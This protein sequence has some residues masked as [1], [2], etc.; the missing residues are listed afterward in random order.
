[1]TEPSAGNSAEQND[2]NPSAEEPA[3]AED[4]AGA[5]MPAAAEEPGEVEDPAEAV[6]PAAAAEEPDAAEIPAEAEDPAEAEEPAAAA[7]E[8]AEAEDP[9]WAEMPA[10]AEIAAEVEEPAEAEKPAEQ[11]IGARAP[12]KSLLKDRG[13]KVRAG[14]GA[15]AAVVLLGIAAALLALLGRPAVSVSSGEALVQVHLSGA[16]TAVT[17]VSATSA[18]RPVALS[19]QTTG[20]VPVAALPQGETVQVRVTAA[21]PSW[22][23][24][25][26]G[27]GVSTSATLR[28]PSAAPTA[29]VAVAAHPGRVT[30]GFNRPVSVVD[31]KAAGGTERVIRLRRPSTTA[32]LAVPDNQS[33]GALQ[34]TAAAWPWERLAASPATV[35]WLQAPKDG[36]PVAA[37]VPAPGSSDQGLDSPIT[38]TFDEPVT[39]ALGSTR[40]RVSPHTAGTWTEPNADTLVFTPRGLGFGPGTAVSVS[41]DHRV[42]VVG[43]SSTSSVALAASGSYHFAVTQVSVLR[44]QQ[45]LAQLHYL[46]LN[47]TPAPGVHEPTT[48]AG[49]V[50][51]LGSPLKGRFSWRW[52]STPAVLKS[53]WQ[54]GSPTVIVKGA[55]MAFMSAADS[56]AYN[57][58]TADAATVSQLANALWKPLLRAAAANKVDPQPYSYV[59]VTKNL[60]ETLVLWENG[61]TV[62]TTPAN[63][64]IAS[65]PTADGTF[66][67][68]VRYTF[69]FMTGTNPDGTKYDDPVYWINY[70]NGGDAVHGF[71]R[72]SYGWPQ[73]LGCVELPIPTAHVAF[74]HLAIGDLVT[75]AG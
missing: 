48:L 22:L 2:Q 17:D 75:V 43:G 8:P 45:I 26:L 74:N 59:H 66:P 3:E 53:K 73:S 7:E 29:R 11:S 51:A 67:V 32:E 34:V 44:L 65:R 63:T 52:Q 41:F 36:V 5:E 16:G 50:A 42:A 18:G 40:P 14:I 1:M 28:A 24:W 47:F 37:A 31:Y 27:S 68:Y 30:L 15:A 69:N 6:E 38:L 46:P 60:P 58:Y 33:G 12:V 4:L 56:S 25:L 20:Y 10:E 71:V 70:F 35:D 19:H 61:K 39:K 72:G 9:A 13:G 64:G 23:H 55:L 21:P 57:G 62:L 49:E 54:P